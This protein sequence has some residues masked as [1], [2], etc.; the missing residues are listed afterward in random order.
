MLENESNLQNKL[1]LIKALQCND[2]FT[3]NKISVK[4]HSFWQGHVQVDSGTAAALIIFGFHVHIITNSRNTSWDK[5]YPPPPPPS[6]CCCCC[7][8][9]L[10]VK[11]LCNACI[12][13][14]MLVTTLTCPSDCCTLCSHNSHHWLTQSL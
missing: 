5:Q 12:L 7:F 9:S 1:K 11:S 14:F 4:K 3:S 2:I 8:C 6:F 13:Y 10:K